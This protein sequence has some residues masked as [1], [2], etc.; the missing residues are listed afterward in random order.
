MENLRVYYVHARQL[1]PVSQN[2]KDMEC[3]LTLTQSIFSPQKILHQRIN[4]KR[5]EGMS[6]DTFIDIFRKNGH[7]VTFQHL[8]HERLVNILKSNEC[9]VVFLCTKRFFMKMGHFTFMYKGVDNIPY[10]YDVPSEHVPAEMYFKKMGYDPN[11]VMVLF[12]VGK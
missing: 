10:V 2:A 12:H 5:E 3:G 4:Y 8:P 6:I 11:D 9:C 1:Q 7:N